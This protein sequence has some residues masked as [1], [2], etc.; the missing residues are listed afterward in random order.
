MSFYRVKTARAGT[1]LVVTLWLITIMSIFGIGLAR[2]SYTHYKYAKF[3]MDKVLSLY[4]INAVVAKNKLERMGDLTT[5]YD[6]P[7]ELAREE[8][9]E[10][11][12]VKVIYSMID[13]ESLI[14]INTAPSSVLMNLPD[15][16]KG[17]S[18]AI[19]SST[20]KP[21]EVK[22]KMLL[23]D[24]IDEEDYLNIKDAVTIH[25]KGRVNINT[26]SEET[27]EMLGMKE[28][29]VDL[30]IRYRKGEDYELFSADDRVFETTS[31]IKDAIAE[32]YSLSTGEEQDLIAFIGKGL[33]SVR[34]EN[35]RINAEIYISGRVVD[36]YLVVIGREEGSK[37]YS[38]K[39][40]NQR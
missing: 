10:A 24:E 17:K 1:T 22:E 8:E 6:V 39:E 7:S 2:T 15:I 18:I 30:V 40:W 34:S 25:G 5:A 14:N 33:L 3:K 31:G 27:L 28:R 38:V 16:S 37:R 35:F 12:D 9:Y 20:F 29:L 36:K 4:A 11:G 21:F 32:E 13:E 26:C 19:A 23:I